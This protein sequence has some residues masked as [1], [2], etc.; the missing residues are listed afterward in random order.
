M[1]SNSAQQAP[2]QMQSMDMM[3]T[4]PL[5]L[6]MHKNTSM[7]SSFAASI[8]QENRMNSML[9]M[10]ATG[11]DLRV[12]QEEQIA[13]QIEQL[14]NNT[15]VAENNQLFSVVA[16]QS[17]QSVNKFLSNLDA[18]IND[19]KAQVEAAPLFTNT[20]M[21][22]N[23][24]T[25]NGMFSASLD[26]ITQQNSIVSAQAAN[27][28]HHHHQTI[29]NQAP[30]PVH[31][32]LMTEAGTATSINHILSFPPTAT[33]STLMDPNTTNGSPL[34]QDVILNSQPTIVLN[35]SPG[36]HSVSS[37]S[38]SSHSPNI[39]NQ[40]DTDIIMNPAISPSMMCQQATTNDG[41][42]I[43]G[44]VPLVDNTL[45]PVNVSSS[46]QQS[47]PMLN[48]MMQN[49]VQDTNQMHH[50][51]LKQTPV[52]VKNMILNAAADILSSEPNSISTETTIN[53]LMSL[54]PGP[55]LT[56]VVHQQ[57][58]EQQ[59]QQQPQASNSPNM[60]LMN[61]SEHSPIVQQVSPHQGTQMLMTQHNPFEN[62]QTQSMNNM[63]T[64]QSNVTTAAAAAQLIDVVAAAVQSDIMQSQ[65]V[66]ND[67]MMSNFSMANH[68]HMSPQ[69]MTMHPQ[70]TTSSGTLCQ[71]EQNFLNEFQ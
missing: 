29:E 10:S 14:V 22:N 34:S 31:Q 66:P 46:P 25:T 13:A 42:L 65:I 39:S 18:T 38:N 28:H 71:A 52:A 32:G 50:I 37:G 44:Q 24:T 5:E 4:T 19:L 53:A 9:D 64:T 23:S 36:L 1:D 55:I 30:F 49:Q 43:V 60:G 61:V 40:S 26:G 70:T 62:Q 51:Q 56:D 58:Q 45:L 41:S 6:I 27:I 17:Q 48:N 35:A 11:V 3:E 68:H 2:I 54:T 15:N 69:I 20:T 8:A 47:P 33:T 16:Q 21:N 59:Q 67:P 7:S 63:Y 12:K 57:Q